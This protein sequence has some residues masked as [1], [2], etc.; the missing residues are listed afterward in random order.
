MRRSFFLLTL[1]CLVGL[2]PGLASAVPKTDVSSTGH[3]TDAR[4]PSVQLGPRPFFLVDDMSNSPLK[5]QLQACKNRAQFTRTD[6]SIGH[7][8]AAL[9]FP[10]HTRESYEAASRM[11]DRSEERRVGKECRSRW[12]PY[13]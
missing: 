6:F 2:L 7:R 10:E 5:Q 9:Q 3:P 1:A 13:H 4:G 8:G 12:S 11:G